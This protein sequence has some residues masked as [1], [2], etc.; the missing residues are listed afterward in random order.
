MTK[1]LKRVRELS[2]D[3]MKSK[4][5]VDNMNLSAVEENNEVTIVSLVSITNN[6]DVDTYNC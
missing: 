6:E 2:T 5:S 3:S 1:R 4:V